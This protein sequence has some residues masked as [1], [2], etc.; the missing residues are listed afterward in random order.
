MTVTDPLLPPTRC[1]SKTVR[2]FK[3]TRGGVQQGPRGTHPGGGLGS[4][5]ETPI[6]RLSIWSQRQ[7]G[8]VV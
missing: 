1:E 4:D 8:L 3:M 2:L 6:H 5:T 7:L